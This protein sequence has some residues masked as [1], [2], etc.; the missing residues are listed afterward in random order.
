M[1]SKKAIWVQEACNRMLM[2]GLR[3]NK[4]QLT[5]ICKPYEYILMAF[6]PWISRAF[7]R[8]LEFQGMLAVLSVVVRLVILLLGWNLIDNTD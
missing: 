1:L 4:C 2:R 5:R 7:T 3:P 8:P 6:G